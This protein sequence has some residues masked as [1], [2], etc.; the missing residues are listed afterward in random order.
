M[1]HILEISSV[2]EA[3]DPAVRLGGVARLRPCPRFDVYFSGLRTCGLRPF[4]LQNIIIT[5]NVIQIKKT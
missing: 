1:W 5:K 4:I 3:Y 2:S